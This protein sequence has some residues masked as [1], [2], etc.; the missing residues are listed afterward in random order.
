MLGDAQPTVLFAARTLCAAPFHWRNPEGSRNCANLWLIADGGG[1][2]QGEGHTY[3]CTPGDFFVQRL[4]KPC[5]GRNLDGPPMDVLWA[6]IGWRDRGG[7]HL[8][9]RVHDH[10]L[11][12]IHRRVADLGFI[13]AMFHRLIAASE[14]GARAEADRWLAC[15]LDEADRASDDHGDERIASIVEAIRREPERTWRVSDLARSAGLPVDAFARRFRAAIGVSPR[16][17]LVRARL[18]AA[19]ALLRMSDAAIGDIATRLG[20]CDIYHFSRR[21]RTHVG[22]APSAYR[23][24]A[25]GTNSG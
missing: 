15:V 5:E 2:W 18:D 20:F 11:P 3:P 16:T 13:A 10:D 12:P 4:W 1:T 14:R 24:G 6:N 19:K 22:C 8:D 7:I 9:L 23:R 17:F 25:S 21:F